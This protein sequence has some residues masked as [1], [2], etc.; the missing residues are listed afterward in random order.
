[1][2]PP[3]GFVKSQINGVKWTIIDSLGR[4]CE[5]RKASG[6]NMSQLKRKV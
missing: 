2:S 5:P 6:Q 1:M 3:F 4:F